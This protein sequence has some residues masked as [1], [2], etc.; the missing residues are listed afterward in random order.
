MPIDL[1]S[2]SATPDTREP[3]PPRARDDIGHA[4]RYVA[5]ILQQ[6]LVENPDARFWTGHGTA[7][8]VDISGFTK[9][10]ERLARKGREG[11]EQITEAIGGSFES[12][13]EVAYAQRWQ[14]AQVR[15]RRAAALVRG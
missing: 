10:S 7:A 2:V 6:H 15:G 9:L 8:F 5:R 13:L 1:P 14:P 11:A 12:I 3:A 4:G